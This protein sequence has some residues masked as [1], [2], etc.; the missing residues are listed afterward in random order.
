MTPAELIARARSAPEALTFAAVLDTI[1]RHYHYTPTAFTNGLGAGRVENPA[2]VNEGS[3]RV[4]AFA[5]LHGLTEADTL[6]LF[7]EHYRSVLSDPNGDNHA[8]I[9]AFMRHGWV[10]VAF[11]S[12][13]LVGR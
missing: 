13:P 12:E 11:A 5:R 8:N 7:A 9:R 10:G 3:C 4:L 2:G 1:G 6:A